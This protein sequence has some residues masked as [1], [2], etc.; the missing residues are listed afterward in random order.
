VIGEAADGHAAVAG[1]CDLRPDVVLMDLAMPGMDGIAATRQVKRDGC[2]RVLVLTSSAEDAS[3]LDALRAGADGYLLKNAAPAEVADA[4]R[5]V[6]AGDP[7]LA[8]DAVRRL[9]RGLAG[10]RPRPE[11]TVTIVFTDV[12]GSTRMVSRLG[13]AGA[14]AVFDRHRRSV[15]AISEQHH[16]HEVSLQGDGFM[17][18]FSG[19][20]AAVECAIA[21]QQASP[22]LPLRVGINTGEVIAERDGYFGGAVFLAARI[23]ERARSGQILVSATTRALVPELAREEAGVAE[24]K[25]LPG[26]Q[27]LFAVPYEGAQAPAADQPNLTPREREV[28]ALLA[29]GL[30]N[31]AIA[32]RLGLS[33]KTVKTH[34]SSLLLKLGV[35]D[36]TQ[37]A[38]LAV[39]EGVR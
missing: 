11:G 4:I 6:A 18:A 8:P 30:S 29:E 1:A 32:A 12:V 38:L 21:I 14:H 36:R 19:A 35:T 17:L 13:D 3:V 15:R 10:E 2:G 28:W 25:G 5:A 23:A 34:V 27:Q 26:T 9:L 22:D 31:K 24:L 33:D 7:L 37:A 39:R 16:G 20:R